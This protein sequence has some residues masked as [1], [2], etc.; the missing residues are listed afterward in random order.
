MK[1]KFING[2]KW[3]I[4]ARK[5]SLRRLCFHR[6]LSVHGEVSLTET[7]LDRDPPGQRP[8][9]S[10]TPSGQRPPRTE[11]PPEQKPPGQN[12]PGTEDGNERAV[13]ILLEC[14]LVWNTRLCNAVMLQYNY[15]VFFLFYAVLYFVYY[16]LRVFLS[17]I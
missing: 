16:G 12:P 3:I 1:S 17:V 15:S 6:C 5:R 7:P 9:W 11:T 10:E 4:T 8:P 2:G 13:R 14:I